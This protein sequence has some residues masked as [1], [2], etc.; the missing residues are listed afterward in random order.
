MSEHSETGNWVYVILYVGIAGIALFSH[1]LPLSTAPSSWAGP[2]VILCLTYVLV[3]RRPKTIPI[4]LIAGV[5]IILDLFLL[6]PPGLL[7][8]YVV[9][10][11]EFLRSRARVNSELP[12]FV[13]WALVASVICAV[14]LGYR[15][16][17]FIV[18][19]DLSTLG[20]SLQHLIGTVL[21]YPVFTVLL[22]WLTLLG[23]TGKLAESKGRSS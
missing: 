3:M 17:L 2:D 20:L 1:L 8:A 7:T 18:A 21:L 11:A 5:F 4:G 22:G 23:T 14:L 9:I 15:F 16:T 19:I 12:F 13:E 10:G 6:R